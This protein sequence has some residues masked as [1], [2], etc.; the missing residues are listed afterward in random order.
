MTEAD[1]IE[2]GARRVVVGLDDSVGARTALRHGLAEARRRGAELEVVTSFVSPERLAVLDRI[3]VTADRAS[4]ARAATA[5][6]RAVVDEVLAAE[7]AEHPDRPVP[8]VVVRAVAGDPGPALTDAAADAELL[9]L[10][11]RGRGGVATTL[12]GSTG[13]WCVRHARCP[14]TIVPGAPA[15]PP[16]PP[17]P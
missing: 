10:G 17:L 6:A 1:D 9:V 4:A 7:R 12:L 16:A 14:L 8:R 5:A 13:W 11:H 3:P 15:V 2:D